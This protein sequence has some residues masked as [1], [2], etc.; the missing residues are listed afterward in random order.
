MASPFSQ[1]MRSLQADNFY[2]TIGGLIVAIVLAVVW[3]HW[4]FTAEV[5]FY[6]TSQSVRVTDKESV[7]SL[8][9]SDAGGAAQRA[10]NLRRR[11]VVAEFPPEA[12]E[13]IRSGQMAFLHLEGKVGKQA[14]AI[15]A[16]VAN[17]FPASQKQK[18]H[19]EF[20]AEIDAEAP[21]PFEEG[22]GGEVKVE[23]D[24]ITPAKLVMRASGL[25][26]DTPPTSS[27]PQTMREPVQDL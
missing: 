1:T 20:I 5:T 2:L 16:V 27:S 26:V 6:E 10:L 15:P 21:N 8:F 17:V 11:L 25:F 4:F 13:S 9:P 7:V 14:G 3:G 12:L 22:V 23:V 24:Y 18:G 19:I